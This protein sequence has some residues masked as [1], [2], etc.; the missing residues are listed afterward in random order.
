MKTETAKEVLKAVA[1]HPDVRGSFVQARMLYN[2]LCS[3]LLPIVPSPVFQEYRNKSEF[4]IGRS[5]DGKETIVGFRF[6][7]YKD[8]TDCVGSPSEILI[9]P[10]SSKMVAQCFQEFLGSST[11]PVFDHRTHEGHWRQLTVRTTRERG[12]IM[13][14][15]EFVVQNTTAED[16]E[17]VKEDIKN[18]FTEGPGKMSGVS[19]FY[20]RPCS[21]K[22]SNSTS[23][24]PY[25]LIYGDGFIYESLLEMK[26][27]ISPSSF[28]Q[29]NT[30]AAE[31]M[32]KLI[33]E[34]TGATQTS[35]VLDIC[36]GTGTIGLSL[37]KSVAKVIGIEMCKEAVEDAKSNAALNGVTNCEYYCA[38]VQD[39]IQD[40]V[41]NLD[42]SDVVA[43]LDPP[44]AGI[45]QV[46]IKALR[47]CQ[48]LKRIVYASCHPM[49]AKTNFIEKDFQCFKEVDSVHD[50]SQQSPQVQDLL[51]RSIGLKSCSADVTRQILDDFDIHGL[52]IATLDKYGV[53]FDIQ[54]RS[55]VLPAFDGKGQ[56][57]GVRRLMCTIPEE[58]E[59]LRVIEESVLPR[60]GPL[61]LFGFNTLS[62]GTK[63]VVLTSTELDALAVFQETQTP[64]L[65]LPNGFSSL[66]QEVLPALERFSKLVLWLGDDMR[67]WEAAKMFAKKLGND[68]CYII[69]PSEDDPSPL[70]ALRRGVRL[71]EV[72]DKAKPIM[73]K[74]IVSFSHLRQEI[75]SEL[76]HAEQV[77]GVK[78]KRYPVLNKLLKGHRRGELTVFTGPTGSGKTTFIS[79]YS[80]DLCMQGVNTLWGSFE[81][82]NVR[83]GKLMLTQ[84]AQ[85]NLSKHLDQFDAWADRFEQ[86]PMY[87]MTFHGQES[88]RKVIE[89]MSHAVYV[90]D[91]AHVVV[92]NLQ[93][94]LGSNGEMA[95]RFTKQDIFISSFRKFATNMNCHVTVVIHPRK[96]TKNRFDGEL[97]VMLLKFE[98]ETLSF[99][100]KEKSEKSKR[101][102]AHDDDLMERNP[103]SAHSTV[104][105]ED[106]DH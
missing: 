21:I 71:R 80:L 68:R 9:L 37:A 67:A 29:V 14:V 105:G 47:M 10:S 78:W 46:V 63:E 74:S 38:K 18:Y 40:I 98:K 73:H 17:K 7:L 36:C 72:L 88:I 56:L 103:L 106:M 42:T 79:D 3:P 57:V 65:A 77:A 95:E 25:E 89:A 90:H 32:Y 24:E 54:T 15:A 8:G 19:T 75:F 94:M 12:G 96:I 1:T 44:R 85:L 84:F 69:R 23:E 52:K 26:F 55:L 41:H 81:I 53:K 82:N 62:D 27:R 91:I 104:Y 64:S 58:N 48:Q 100:G 11:Y 86:L 31:V 6:G 59:N 92:D 76:L 101:S 34:W 87:F 93:F 70:E 4:S 22:T 20:F 33:Q 39:C 99:V 35:T 13:G 50:A 43:I 66:P 60:T 28:F 49:I 97:G 51:D 2:G 45:H 61:G 5:E 102:D 83:L 30:A 16:R